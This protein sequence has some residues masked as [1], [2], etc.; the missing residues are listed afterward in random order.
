MK[1][2]WNVYTTLQTKRNVE[3]DFFSF[4]KLNIIIRYLGS[5]N[6]HKIYFIQSYS[7]QD[8]LI[9]HSY[10]EGF[11][12]DNSTGC[13]KMT[14]PS[15]LHDYSLQSHNIPNIGETIIPLAQES[16]ELLGLSRVIHIIKGD[17]RTIYFSLSVSPILNAH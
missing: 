3:T 10:H 13:F 11:L 17:N 9:A 1:R 4:F 15:P 8:Q 5:K 7:I 12:A 2:K 16:Q 14:N 6:T